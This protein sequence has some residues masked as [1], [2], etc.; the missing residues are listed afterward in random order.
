VAAE[1][2]DGRAAAFYGDLREKLGMANLMAATLDAQDGIDVLVNASLVVAV[3]DPLRA[4]ADQM[5]AALARN[6]TANLRLSQIVAKRMI[7]IA[8]AETGGPADRA[9]LNLSSTYARRA[10]PE[11]LAYSVSCAALDQLSRGMALALAPHRIRVNA[12]ALGRID[13]RRAGAEATDEE[14][15][16]APAPLGR[17][18]APQ[19]AAEAALFLVSP[20]ASFIT[21]QVLGVDG[22][23]FVAAADGP[24]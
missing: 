13:G 14:A 20:C 1:G 9:I 17:A 7:E 12:L 16:D 23:R 18:G 24:A 2:L 4:E 21:G 6:V 15:E 22:G 10:P 19:D 3:S 11:L 5:E 8:A